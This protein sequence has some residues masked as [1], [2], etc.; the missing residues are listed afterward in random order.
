MPYSL[1]ITLTE[2]KFVSVTLGLCTGSS[3]L[4]TPY[5]TAVPVYKSAA[6]YTKPQY[7]NL[8][9]ESGASISSVLFEAGAQ[10]RRRTFVTSQQP[11]GITYTDVYLSVVLAQSI[12]VSPDG[13]N[14]VFSLPFGAQSKSYDDADDPSK[15]LITLFNSGVPDA[16]GVTTPAV[17]AQ[18]YLTLPPSVVNDGNSNNTSY[19]QPT[20]CA[21]TVS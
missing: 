5:V 15:Y 21:M 2:F 18:G 20:V 8:Y 12:P 13:V 14:A 19:T 16:N 7:G 3:S 1:D 4:R 17:I 11:G 9:N 10:M 6:L